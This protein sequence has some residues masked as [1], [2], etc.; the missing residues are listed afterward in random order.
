MRPIIDGDVIIAKYRHLKA[1]A[2]DSASFIKS[3]HG[4]IKVSKGNTKQVFIDSLPY[5]IE[6]DEI[7]QKAF[8]NFEMTHAEYLI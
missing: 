5:M 2:E 6:Q 3:Y 8:K 4:A 7:K 1:E